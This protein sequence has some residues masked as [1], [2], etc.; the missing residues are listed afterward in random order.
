M[1]EPAP[2]LRRSMYVLGGVLVSVALVTVVVLVVITTAL[3][4][5]T[6]GAD[7]EEKAAVARGLRHRLSL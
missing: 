5:G 2:T 3:S 1:K 7:S 4:R 6:R